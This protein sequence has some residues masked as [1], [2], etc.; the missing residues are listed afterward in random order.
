VFGSYIHGIFDDIEFT[1]TF[2]N[3]IRKEKGLDDLS[4][5]VQSF[6]EFKETEYEKL[7]D[8]VRKHIDMDKVY[9]IIKAW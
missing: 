6:D 5:K 9:D 1:R 2:L 3:D 8:V 4:S 7:A